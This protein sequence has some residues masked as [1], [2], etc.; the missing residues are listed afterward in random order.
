LAGLLTASSLD[1]QNLGLL[2]NGTVALGAVLGIVTG[3]AIDGDEG[4]MQ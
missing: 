3:G 4:M 2:R 1:D